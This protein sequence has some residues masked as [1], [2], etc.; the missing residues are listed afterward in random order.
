MGNFHAPVLETSCIIFTHILLTRS[1]SYSTQL[2]T[3]T[4]SV[5]CIPA[6][7]CTEEKKRKQELFST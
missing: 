5:E 7:V 1:Q 3:L 2:T 4:E 6:T